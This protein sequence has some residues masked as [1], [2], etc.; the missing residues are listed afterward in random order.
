M[1]E[2]G[3]VRL[4]SNPAYTDEAVTPAEA[5]ELLRAFTREP[6]HRFLQSPPASKPQIYARA[7]GHGQV[8][9]AW[10]VE[11]ARRNNARFVTFDSRVQGH[12][13]EERLVEVI[14]S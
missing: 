1:T 11:V 3:F 7:L 5:A 9:D 12:A 14:R 8:N 2:L 13:G 10:L 6:N 4:S